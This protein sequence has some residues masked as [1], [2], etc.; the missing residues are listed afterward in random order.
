MLLFRKFYTNEAAKALFGKSSLQENPT[1]FNELKRPMDL[2]TNKQI[3]Q[4]DKAVIIDAADASELIRN[5]KVKTLAIKGEEDYVP[6]PTYIETIIVKGGHIT[7][8]EKPQ[9]VLSVIQKLSY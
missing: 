4:T 3:K 6:E 1:L 5:L 7:P 8:L 2:L 9:E